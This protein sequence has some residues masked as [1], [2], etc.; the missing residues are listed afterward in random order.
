MKNE[1]QFILTRAQNSII[2]Q[3]IIIVI[4]LI[5][6]LIFADHGEYIST[7]AK[8]AL[9]EI[10]VF[11]LLFY[12]GVIKKII[13]IDRV[14]QAFADGYI[15]QGL[16][17]QTMGLNPQHEAMLNKLDKILDRK[18]MFQI[19]KKQAE[20]LALQNQI[21]P[22]FLYNTLE[23]IRSEA[24]LG[25][26]TSVAEMSEALAKFFRYTISNINSLVTIE[27]ELENVYNYCRIQ[28]YRFGDKIQL[29]VKLKE[30][31][32]KIL[33][34]KIPK[35]ILQPIVENSIRH[36]IEP[37][38]SGGVITMR[39]QIVEQ[40]MLIIISDNGV[41]MEADQLNKLNENLRGLQLEADSK[42]ES[43][44][45]GGIAMT[46]VNTRLKLLFGDD[47]GICF[48]ST[49]NVGTDVEITIPYDEV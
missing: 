23:G 7:L 32:N 43:D 6:F 45:I 9:V 25:G 29:N 15:V 18:E 19:S 41:G 46:N 27:D 37:L 48:Y 40:R 2:I 22:H 49:A 33:S 20:Y 5:L 13:E 21:N 11:S 26:M 31:E 28:K 8:V 4:E 12:H 47:Y 36:G 39:F 35:L 16:F 17:E 14:Y 42:E 3:S 10:T 30:E 1:K 38:I 44:K 34:A 24:L